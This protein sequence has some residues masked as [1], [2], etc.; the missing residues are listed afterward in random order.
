M[1]HKKKKI[2]QNHIF[3]PS[4]KKLKNLLCGRGLTHFL[5]GMWTTGILQS[6]GKNADIR[7]LPKFLIKL[8]ESHFFTFTILEADWTIKEQS[9]ILMPGPSIYNFSCSMT[10]SNWQQLLIITWNTMV[11][12]TNGRLLLGRQQAALF[13]TPLLAHQSSYI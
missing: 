10:S 8:I 11:E 1:W 4:F 12:T 2:L 7:I 9:T 3:Q 13:I 6:A 5:D